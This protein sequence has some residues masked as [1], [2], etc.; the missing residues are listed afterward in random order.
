MYSFLSSIVILPGKPDPTLKPSIS[1]TGIMNVVAEDVK[2]S[3]ESLASSN[4]NG[5]SSKM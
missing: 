1:T 3:N 5:F 4:E 2:A